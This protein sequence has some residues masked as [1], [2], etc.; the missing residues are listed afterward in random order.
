MEPYRPT[1][2]VKTTSYDTPYAHIFRWKRRLGIHEGQQ[3]VHYHAYM[4]P[5]I[6]TSRVS[7]IHSSIPLMFLALVKLMSWRVGGVVKTTA[8]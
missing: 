3:I 4:Q 5:S 7:S 6:L 8:V 1:F 2:M